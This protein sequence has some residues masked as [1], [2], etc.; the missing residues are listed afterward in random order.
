MKKHQSFCKSVCCVSIRLDGMT[1]I[2][3]RGGKLASADSRR[4]CILD[5]VDALVFL[6]TNILLDFYRIRR[7][8]VSVSY[9]ELIDSHHDRLITGTQI[10][11]EYKKNRQQVIL[12]SIKGMKYPDWNALGTPAILADCK[13]AQAMANRRKEISDQ[14]KKLKDRTSR[15]LRQPSYNDPVYKTLQRLF[16]AKTALNLNRENK[17]TLHNTKSCP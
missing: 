10:E 9:L 1:E 15:I 4:E 17:T 13:A 8:D 6:D 14:Q 7:S 16:K 5:S 2:P 12:E 11:M 3:R